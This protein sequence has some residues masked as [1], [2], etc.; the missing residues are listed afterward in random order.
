MELTRQSVE[1]FLKNQE[2]LFPEPVAESYE[3][4]V[5]FLEDNLAV[6]LGS[7]SEVRE[8]FEEEGMDV[9]EL[10]DEE[11][12]EEC[13]VFAVPDGTFLIVEA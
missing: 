11:L 8:Y 13:E 2:K 9:S 5:E 3:E 4:A 10:T 7:I 1:T 12:Y 6:L